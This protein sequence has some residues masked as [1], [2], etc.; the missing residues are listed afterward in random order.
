MR[1]SIHQ[2]ERAHFFPHN[3]ITAHLRPC[4]SSRAALSNA[5]KAPHKVAAEPILYVFARLSHTDLLKKIRTSLLYAEE[6]S[7]PN[8]TS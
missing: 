5:Y 2:E 3:G 1:G 8:S 4:P 7:H 6:G